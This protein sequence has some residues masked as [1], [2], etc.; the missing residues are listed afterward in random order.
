M[1]S[2]QLRADLLSALQALATGDL[3][4]SATALL[5][6]LGYASH[7]TLNLTTQPQAFTKEVETLVDG[8]GVGRDDGA[9]ALVA[10]TDQLKQQVGIAV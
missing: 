1:S 2:K 8:H 5:G 6:T 10:P 7:K 9:F 3:R 4:T